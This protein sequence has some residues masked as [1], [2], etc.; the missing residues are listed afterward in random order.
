MDIKLYTSG[1][2]SAMTIPAIN[3]ALV[4]YLD[5][6]LERGETFTLY[7]NGGHTWHLA[8]AAVSGGPDRLRR[9]NPAHVIG[10]DLFGAEF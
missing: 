9:V 5:Y 7:S 6:H 2:I 1:N 4:D 8:A 10:Y 3:Q